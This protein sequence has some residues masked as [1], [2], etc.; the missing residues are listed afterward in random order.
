MPI[1]PQE[2]QANK[3]SAHTVSPAP[4][5]ADWMFARSRPI[6]ITLA[7]ICGVICVIA[8]I[9]HKEKFD[10]RLLAPLFAGCFAGYAGVQCLY[11]IYAGTLDLGKI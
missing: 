7:L 11:L 2:T 8:R 6:G 5:T 4:T 10:E 1:L 3:K 9:R